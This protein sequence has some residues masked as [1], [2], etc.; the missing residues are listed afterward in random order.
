MSWLTIH[1]MVR[2]VHELRRRPKSGVRA[3]RAD[4]SLHIRQNRL[5]DRWIHT[6]KR[7][8]K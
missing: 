2:M 1:E 5:E 3:W 6:H 7:K 4:R 8:R